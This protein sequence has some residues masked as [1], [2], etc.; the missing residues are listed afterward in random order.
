MKKLLIILFI[1]LWFSNYLI[2]GWAFPDYKVDYLVWGEFVV[3]RGIIFELMF[4]ILLISSIFRPSREAKALIVST[5]VIVGLS[6]VDKITGVLTYAYTDIIV[7]AFA[8][9]VGLYVYRKNG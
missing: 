1:V 3:L 9:F 4:F 6:I 8:V 5:S 7:V 2:C